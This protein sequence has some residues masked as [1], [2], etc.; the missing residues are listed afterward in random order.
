MQLSEG[1]FKQFS[2][3]IGPVF[4]HLGDFHCLGEGGGQGLGQ[5]RSAYA[6]CVRS[7]T[8]AGVS[9]PVNGAAN[10]D[11]PLGRPPLAQ[12]DQ[13]IQRTIRRVFADRTTLTIAHRLDT[14]I[15]SDKILTMAQGQV[16]E[17]ADPNTLLSEPRSMFNK[18][19]EDTGPIAS[20][21]LRAMAAAGPNDT[22]AV[23]AIGGAQAA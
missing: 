8:Y 13:L 12:T 23:P 10:A 6:A 14:V 20:A 16:T 21:A 15:F 5:A 17:F 22:A 4:A 11:D 1:C 18:L 2:L 19:V 7:M 3:G 9:L